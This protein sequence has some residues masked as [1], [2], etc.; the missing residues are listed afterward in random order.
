[1]AHI[2]LYIN[3]V[4]IRRYL[5]SCC[6]YVGYFTIVDETISG[7]IK[8]FR[9]FSSFISLIRYSKAGGWGT[10]CEGHL[11]DACPR[12]WQFKRM[13]YQL[14]WNPDIL[15]CIARWKLT[16]ISQSWM[17]FWFFGMLYGVSHKIAPG[18]PVLRFYC[19]P[20]F[21]ST[22]IEQNLLEYLL[23]KKPP[24]LRVLQ[25]CRYTHTTFCQLFS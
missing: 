10:C 20:V 17:Q 24:F 11:V 7:N 14:I 5:P 25:Q 8:H 18:F 6:T 15:R 9:I 3:C 1:M 2:Y 16:L 21:H 23:H 4:S 12:P 13:A 19:F 22:A